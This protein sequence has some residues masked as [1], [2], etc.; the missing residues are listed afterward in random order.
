MGFVEQMFSTVGGKHP[1][2]RKHSW[3]WFG[4]SPLGN[5][6]E[7]RLEGSCPCRAGGLTKEEAAGAWKAMYILMD[8]LTAPCSGVSVSSL[9]N[10]CVCLLVLFSMI[11]K[12]QPPWDS[13]FICYLYKPNFDCRGRYQSK[14]YPREQQLSSFYCS[15]TFLY[16]HW[17]CFS[18]SFLDPLTS[19][20]HQKLRLQ[21]SRHL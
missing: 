4:S 5:S 14:D 18:F 19:L 8:A 16:L 3:W 6:T 17:H 1:W 2:C 13:C 12:Q 9:C 20:K 15:F 10:Q 11:T 21:S 7:R